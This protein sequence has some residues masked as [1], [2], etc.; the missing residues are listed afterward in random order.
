MNTSIINTLPTVIMG[1]N[2]AIAKALITNLTQQNRRCAAI[3]RNHEKALTNFSENNLVKIY[4]ADALNSQEVKNVFLKISEELGTPNAFVHCVGS[5]VLSPLH[6]TNDELWHQTLSLNLT[7]AM[8]GLREF[9]NNARNHHSVWHAVL[10]SSCAAALGL[11]NHEAISAAKGGLEAMARSTA[12]TYAADGLRINVV[13]PGLTET[14]MAKPFLRSDALK[15]A[16]AKQYPLTG[17]NNA[18][19]VADAIAWLLKPESLRITGAILPVDGGFAKIRP[20][21]K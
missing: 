12:A 7:S 10:I 1:A 14:E 13:A 8:I 9:I 17:I 6:Q 19:D 18:K 4:Q 2:S 3:V 16:S 5:I 21:I 11:A 15:Q 20:F